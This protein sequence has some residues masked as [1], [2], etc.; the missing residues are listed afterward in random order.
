MGE[1][2]HLRGN[3]ASSGGKHGRA[4]QDDPR[5][6]LHRRNLRFRQKRGLEV[7]PTKRGKGTKIMVIADNRSLPVAVHLSSASPHEVTLVEKTLASRFTNALPRRLV[8]DRAYDS[9]P[10]DRRLFED[11]GLR[12]VSPHRRGRTR[13]K[14]QDGRELRRYKRRWKI[15]RL[16]AWLQGYRRL[17]VR[18]EY[19]AAN[20]LCFVHLA[21]MLILMRNYF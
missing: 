15:E 4:K 1:A 11:F 14:T 16:N 3:P 12:L 7:G 5:R 20:F 10:L 21:C 2:R 17:V 6:V 8:A 9:D 18:Y 19:H 13:P